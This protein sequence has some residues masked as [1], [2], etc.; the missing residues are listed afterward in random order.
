MCSASKTDAE[1]SRRIGLALGSN[2]G[3]RLAMLEAACD[4]LSEQFGDL[5]LSCVYE[6]DPVGCP[7]G[8]PPFLNACVE[9]YSAM[10]PEEILEHCQRIEHELGR[11]RHG[12]YGEPR[13]CDIDVIYCGELVQ[14]SPR[15]TLPHPRAHERRFVLQPLCDI[16]PLLTLPGQSETVQALLDKLPQFP[17]VTPFDL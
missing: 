4:R 2:V 9:L 6:T 8:S 12:V 7:A 11:T 5:R 14:T 10:P 13:P 15:L 3:D 17:S 16:D 1:Q